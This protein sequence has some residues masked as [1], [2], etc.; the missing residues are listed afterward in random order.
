MSLDCF[1]KVI[2]VEGDSG[3]FA[4]PSGAFLPGFIDEGDVEN[5]DRLDWVPGAGSY[6]TIGEGPTQ[7]DATA[8]WIEASALPIERVRESRLGH[9]VYALLFD[10]RILRGGIAFVDGGV[11]TK[12]RGTP[13]ECWAWF[14]E[15]IPKP[16]TGLDNPVMF[17]SREAAKAPVPDQHP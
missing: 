4:F 14:L 2:P 3:G 17:W 11:E 13:A 5:L 1:G 12:L 8:L 10:P 6:F 16:W 15:R 9:A 7:P